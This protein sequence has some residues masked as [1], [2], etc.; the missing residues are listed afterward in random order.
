MNRRELV[1]K[2]Q[3]LKP[4][5]KVGV[6]FG[7]IAALSGMYY[8]MF[9]SDLSDATTAA[10]SQQTQLRADREGYEKR[11][12]EYLAYRNELVQLQQEQRELLRALPKNAELASFLQNLQEQAELAGI[13][14]INYFPDA[15]APE[16][17]YGKIPVRVEVRGTFHG[18]TKFF[19]NISEL[20]RIVNIESPSFS[21]ERTPSEVEGGAPK[22]RAKFVAATF[23]YQD[24]KTGSGT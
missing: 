10:E 17:L 2:V 5:A 1:A 20:R 16:D 9:Y 23:K 15:E 21:V 14:I 22:L 3:R 6:T 18:I 12:R 19:K 7:V 13:E 11:K 4:V 8:V 24:G